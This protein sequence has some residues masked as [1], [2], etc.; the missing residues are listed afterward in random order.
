MGSQMTT[1]FRTRAAALFV[2]LL[3]AL[4][5]GV[6]VGAQPAQA[7]PG[8]T[9]FGFC[10]HNNSASDPFYISSGS[11]PRNTCLSDPTDNIASFVT[12]NTGVQ[13][14]LFR[15]NTCGG[16]HFVIHAGVNADLAN[17]GYNNAVAAVMRTSTIG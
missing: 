2:S 6:A 3:M 11:A 12:E 15:T 14:W 5:L 4:G 8:C 9:Q 17:S 10:L 13:W 7:A 1:N 16:S